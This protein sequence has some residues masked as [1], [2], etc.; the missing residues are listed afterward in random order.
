[1][2]IGRV[3]NMPTTLFDALDREKKSK[4]IRVGVSEFA[5]YGYINSSTNR[6]VKNSGISKGSLFQYFKNKEEF[7]L[8]ILDGITSELTSALASKTGELSEQLFKR[9]IDYSVLEFTW[10]IQNPDKFRIIM[11]AFA[12]NDTEISR[13]VAAKYNLTG[14]GIY[15]S[16]LE[17]IDAS[18]F[19]WDK[20][21]TFDILKWFLTGFNED[22]MRKANPQEGTDI[23]RLKSD[24]VSCLTDYM[25]ILK[26]G[27]LC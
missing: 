9:V 14:E 20:Q 3:K 13:K 8:Y 1:M 21:K 2:V 18:E 19:K 5:Q 15:Y 4:I 27:L 24:Y 12:K 25:G 26:R 7:Y 22:F 17:G 16:L 23:E 10:Y 11:E 6:I